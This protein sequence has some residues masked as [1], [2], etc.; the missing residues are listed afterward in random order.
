MKSSTYIIYLLYSAVFTMDG[1]M[2]WFFHH[3]MYLHITHITFH[4]HHHSK[5]YTSK[6]I[7][8]LIFPWESCSLPNIAWINMAS[9][10]LLDAWKFCAVDDGQIFSYKFHIVCKC[11]RIMA[12]Q[13][14]RGI[15]V[16]HSSQTN[17]ITGGKVWLSQQHVIGVSFVIFIPYWCNFDWLI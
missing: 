12:S 10:V 16:A 9:T 13:C 5:F 7:A 14:T 17:G 8:L 11:R 15:P 6:L 3:R 2:S 4:Q 1:H